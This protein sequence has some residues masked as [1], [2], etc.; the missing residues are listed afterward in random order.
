MIWKLYIFFQALFTDAADMSFLG[1]KAS[2]HVLGSLT[3]STINNVLVAVLNVNISLSS[4]D[5]VIGHQFHGYVSNEINKYEFF[6]SQF[7]LHGSTSGLNS[8]QPEG[9]FYINT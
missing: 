4:C 6:T 7:F 2:L 3:S 8:F 9:T 5:V 1:F